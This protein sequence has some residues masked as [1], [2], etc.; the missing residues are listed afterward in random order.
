MM[1]KITENKLRNKTKRNLIIFTLVAMLCGWL[2]VAL[3]NLID[4][5]HEESLGMLIFIGTPL[6][7]VLVLRAFAGDGWKDAGFKPLFKG[8][9]KW[10]IISL[11]VFP[12]LTLTVVFIGY[13][14]GWISLKGFDTVTYLQAFGLALI[15]NFIK[16]IPEEFVWRGYLTPKLLSVGV[17]DYKL[18]A[19]V[20]V[21]WGA[22]HIPYYLY[23][24]ERDIVTEFTS[25]N[26]T[27]FVSLSFIITIAWSIVFIEI[28]LLT[29]SIWPAVLMHMVEDAFV[30]P[31][32]LDKAFQIMP[33]KD[34][35][36]HPVMGVLSII[37]YTVVGLGLRSIRINSQSAQ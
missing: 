34:L 37:L 7:T 9:V 29:K 12:V 27:V 15:P 19:L 5:P 25:L 8:N 18:Y 13:A 32:V 26:I 4:Q 17:G 3:N 20:G 14:L 35:I 31:M 36:I 10:Y 21:I 24:L 33:G 2:G 22:W 23:F 28:W 6:L 30:N 11:F 16:N 1:I